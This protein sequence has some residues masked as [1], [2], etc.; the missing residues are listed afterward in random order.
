[1]I[2]EIDK[3]PAPYT[4]SANTRPTTINIQP[5]V[6]ISLSQDNKQYE[7]EA[8]PQPS[9]SAHHSDRSLRLSISSGNSS[10]SASSCDLSSA[11]EETTDLSITPPPTTSPSPVLSITSNEQYYSSDQDEYLQILEPT[12]VYPPSYDTLPPGGCPKFAIQSFLPANPGSTL[13]IPPPAYTPTVYKIGVVARKVECVTPYEISNHKSWKYL[14]MELN[15]TQ[16]NFYEIPTI[17]EVS[18]C[19]YRPNLLS[20]KVTS[21]LK[22]INSRFTSQYDLKFHLY[23]KQLGLL[24]SKKLVRSYSLQYAKVGLATDYTKK[25]NV[26]RMR[27]ESEQFLVEF[28]NPQALLDWNL[29]LNVG[30]GV[31]LDIEQRSA[32]KYRTIPRRRRRRNTESTSSSGSINSA[33]SMIANRLR[34]S[35]DPF[36]GRLTKL[37]EKLTRSK[38]SKQE[39][40]QTPVVAR[41]VLA[42]SDLA[43]TRSSSVPNLGEL[44]TTVASRSEEENSAEEHEGFEEEADDDEYD[45]EFNQELRNEEGTSQSDATHRTTSFNY[46]P[47]DDYK[48]NPPPEKP[49]SPRRHFR[50]CF[51]CIKPLRVDDPWLNKQVVIPTE[52]SPVADVIISRTSSSVSLATVKSTRSRSASNA[53]ANLVKLP[54]HYLREYNVSA[55]GLVPTEVA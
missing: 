18:L 13:T 20:Q 14:L 21:Y 51:R 4:Y 24:N 46:T 1:M 23:C 2:S 52:T 7:Q 31:S 10:L 36:R 54:C 41:P 45:E 37:R 40:I 38:S 6:P 22:K 35:S 47:S 9:P 5:L 49:R 3:H 8:S 42:V 43:V 19:N 32:P 25:E 44:P 15:S 55:N 39:P 33:T 26:L 34:S 12:P 48:W 16:L 50:H 29:S 30:M 53:S 11:V 17:F 27:A 28:D